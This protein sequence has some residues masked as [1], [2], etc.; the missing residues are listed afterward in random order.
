MEWCRLSEG[1]RRETVNINGNVG[2]SVRD[3][4][5]VVSASATQEL[6]ASSEFGVETNSIPFSHRKEEN[7]FPTALAPSNVQRTS[8][9]PALAELNRR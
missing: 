1:Y 4:C 2:L 6:D 3:S 7:R 8:S 5:E 9:V